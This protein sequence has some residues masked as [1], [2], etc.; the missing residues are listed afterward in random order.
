MSSESRRM[1]GIPLVIF[2]TV[3]YGGMS[4]LSLLMDGDLGYMQNP[5]R[6]DLWQPGMHT[7]FFL[8]VGLSRKLT[9]AIG[10]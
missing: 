7:V 1:A 10:T 4:L 5:L 6:Q 3:I 8:S 9:K 2:P